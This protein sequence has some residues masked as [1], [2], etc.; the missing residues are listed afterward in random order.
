MIYK[1]LV[2][3]APV[4]GLICLVMP[5]S[6]RKW[7][8]GHSTRQFLRIHLQALTQK[9]WPLNKWGHRHTVN[10]RTP[11]PHDRVAVRG[12]PEIGLLN[13]LNWAFPGVSLLTPMCPIENAALWVD[14]LYLTSQSE[15]NEG[16]VRVCKGFPWTGNRTSYTWPK[17]QGATH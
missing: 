3:P 16:A 4:P 12:G 14:L 13:L 6:K 5:I 7:H 11:N 10:L 9:H 2:S 17:A 15:I 8:V 1:C